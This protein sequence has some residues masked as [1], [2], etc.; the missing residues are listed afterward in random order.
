MKA[1]KVTLREKEISKGKKSLYLDFYPAIKNSST[2]KETR[3]EFLGLYLYGK[4]KTPSETQENKDTRN[5]AERIR[6]KRF[7]EIQ[8][9]IYG[10]QSD[11]KKKKSFIDFFEKIVKD[12]Y[13]SE[14]NYGNWKSSLIHFKQYFTNGLLMG[15]LS[16]QTLDDYRDYLLSLDL[17]Q[18]TKHSYFNKV[19]A[20][21]K[22]AYKKG[23]ISDNYTAKV[24]TIKAEETKREFVTLSEL[25]K[26]AKT[27][28]E[29][30]ILKKAFLFSALTGLRHSD[31]KN[32]SWEDLDGNDKDGYYIRFRQKKTKGIERLPIPKPARELLGEVGESN[33]KI[34]EDLIYSAWQNLKLRE[35]VMKAEIKKK[36]TFHCARH[37]FA[38]IQLELGTDIY[39]VS[40]LLGHK[41]LRTTQ[42]YA[43]VVDKTKTDAMNKLNDLKL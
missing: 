1:I 3:R 42:I 29:N 15:E 35:W 10:F 34:F 41:E 33:E 22:E 14:G 26:L 17:A 7:L 5:L 37:S 20:A 16:V 9:E 32:L 18:N 23:L 24:S 4:S 27:E 2:G 25:Q 36:I 6:N 38:T 39:T 21:I 13:T 40:K 31:I 11:A 43:K 28:C 19:R 8:N 12:R 30:P